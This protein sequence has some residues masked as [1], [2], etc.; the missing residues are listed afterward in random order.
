MTRTRAQRYSNRCATART[1]RLRKS[2]RAE[3]QRGLPTSSIGQ[4]RSGL[5]EPPR[6]LASR[7]RALVSAIAIDFR[8]TTRV[9]LG[10]QGRLSSLS[11]TEAVS[12]AANSLATRSCMV[13]W[14]A[15]LVACGPTLPALPSPA[16]LSTAARA[17]LEGPSAVSF[18]ASA[19]THSE[20]SGFE[21][22]NDRCQRLRVAAAFALCATALL[23][24]L[25][26]TGRPA[27][28]PSRHPAEP[29]ACK[30]YV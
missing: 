7:N 23:H 8:Y 2:R 19:Q 21:P 6:S 27:K 11:A 16:R 13:S 18:A 9:P 20:P 15:G 29:I 17:V 5:R 14:H 4:T 24:L 1:Q 30:T 25:L 3:R 28:S 12:N 26:L 22:R 10:C